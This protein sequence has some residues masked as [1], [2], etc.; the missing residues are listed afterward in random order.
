MDF[1]LK[2]LARKPQEKAGEFS[3]DAK[4]DDMFRAVAGYAENT[5]SPKNFQPESIAQVTKNT[6]LTLILMPE[7][8]PHFPPFNLA[9]LSAVAR[10]EGFQTEILDINVRAYNL[11]KAKWEKENIVSYPLW[12]SNSTWR[13]MGS[14][15]YETIHPHLEP[16]LHEYLERIEKFKPDVVGFTQ[17]YSNQ[18]PTNWMAQ[19][20][21]QRL[22]G[23]KIAIGGSNVQN[24]S[25]AAKEYY[26][27][28]VNG[29][30]EEAILKI[31]NEVESGS[32]VNGVT[33][34][35]QPEEQRLSISDLPLPDYSTID[36]NDYE[37]PN[38]VNSEFSRGC[39]AKCT[40][41]EET[42]YF[43]YRQRGYQDVIREIEY[44]Y[45]NKGTNV[46]WF[47]DSLV[48]GSLKELRA[49]CK[50][51]IT[52]GLQIKWTGYCRCDGRMDL[53]FFKDLAASGCV[54]LNYGIESGSQKVLNDMN[55]GVTVAEMEQNFRD[56]KEVGIYSATNW[57]IGFP[58]ETPQDFL[59]TMTFLWRNRNMNIN[60]IGAGAGY[61]L[62]IET[63]V[64]QNVDRYNLSSHKYMGHWITKDFKLA[65]L[66]VMTRVKCFNILMDNLLTEKKVDY[67]YRPNLRKFHYTIEFEDSAIQ[68]EIEY[69]NFEYQIIKD[70]LNPFAATLVNEIWPLLRILWRTRGG[71][72]LKLLFNPKIDQEEFGPKFDPG[73]YSA[74]YEFNISTAGA[75]NAA[76]NFDFKQAAIATPQETGDPNRKGPFVAQDYSRVKSQSST[77]ARKIAKPEWGEEGR[78]NEQFAKLLKEEEIL[79][80]TVDLTFNHSWQGRG[81][82]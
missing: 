35:K 32:N 72:K 65:G 76:F 42:H 71:Y 10:A 60:N 31:L 48:N 45:N 20:I 9:R 4:H 59:D 5:A 73:Y 64:G 12:E 22:P 37:I 6:K 15:Y 68:N 50:E 7:W 77:R 46:I 36:F 39:I 14:K 81:N 56:G 16:L 75:W 54:M 8:S 80:K 24:G 26:D 53:E 21:K 29:E 18:E 52:R 79:N 30:G 61:G 70:K 66:H 25:F 78:S 13:W 33:Y 43:K 41:C 47:I 63:I 69:E 55:K 38:G 67:P 44:L 57:I 28:V 3:I 82:W 62:G 19:Q 11:Y 1:K 40:F 51:I 58:T 49:F 34:I 74:E 2:K 23:C 27:F 17:Y